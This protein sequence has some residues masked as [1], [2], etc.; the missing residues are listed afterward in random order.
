MIEYKKDNLRNK[1]NGSLK[2]TVTE[3]GT[4]HRLDR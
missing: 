2:I 4:R 3:I 1:V